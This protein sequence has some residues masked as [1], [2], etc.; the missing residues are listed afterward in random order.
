MWGDQN[1]KIKRLKEIEPSRGKKAPHS[2]YLGGALSSHLKRLGILGHRHL[3][4]G[5][6]QYFQRGT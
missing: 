1:L 4:V 5:S 6:N 2:A 3:L